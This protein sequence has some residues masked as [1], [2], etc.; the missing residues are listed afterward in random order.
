MNSKVPIITPKVKAS[1]VIAVGIQR[2]DVMIASAIKTTLIL[3]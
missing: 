3:S 2:G 1:I